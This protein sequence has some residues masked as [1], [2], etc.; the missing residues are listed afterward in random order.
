MIW[1]SLRMRDALLFDLPFE[2]RRNETPADALARRAKEDA[3]ECA[4]MIR[5]AAGCL[6]DGNLRVVEGALA[7]LEEFPPPV[8]MPGARA[9]LI[10]KLCDPSIVAT[11]SMR[12]AKRALGAMLIADKEAG[13]NSHESVAFLRFAEKLALDGDDPNPLL[14]V[15]CRL[16][17]DWVRNRRQKLE[18]AYDGAKEIIERNLR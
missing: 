11:K 9:Q 15:I 6:E 8:E 2:T 7:F 5:A 4:E 10:S 1:T 14:A 17:P 18:E 12:L 3:Y 13:V 16:D